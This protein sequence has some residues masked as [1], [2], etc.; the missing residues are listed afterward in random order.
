MTIATLP[1]TYQELRWT[2]D[3]DPMAAETESD[4]E[5]FE[6]DVLHLI[7][8]ILGSNLDDPN[9][10]IGAVEYLSGTSLHLSA[11]PAL[12]D[13]QLLEDARCSSSTSTLT[14]Q[15]DGSYLIGVQCVVAGQVLGL[16][17]ILGPDGLT[18]GPR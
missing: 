8:E 11:M 4:L 9:R 7:D 6:Q 10:G 13:A 2:D 18:V 14:P 1:L 12:I 5:S 15:A 3:M 17:Y 16:S